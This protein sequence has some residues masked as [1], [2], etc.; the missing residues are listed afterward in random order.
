MRTVRNLAIASVS[1]LSLAT[2]AYAQDAEVD[3]EAVSGTEIIVSARRRDEQIQEVPMVVQAVTAQELANLNIREFKDIQSLVPGLSLGQSA[4]GIGAQASLRGIAFDVNASGNNG[5]IEF[6]MNDAHISAGMLFQSLFDV[7]QIEVQR[8]PQG[9][10]RGRASPSGSI[11][12]TTKKPDLNEVGGYMSGTVNDIGGWNVNGAMNVPIIADKLAI[13][14]AGIVDENDDNEVRSI[15]S[16]LEPSRKTQGIRASVQFNPFDILDL[17]FSYTSSQRK[18][19]TFDQ[20]VS[21][22]IADPTLPASPL[23]INGNQRLS[24]MNVPRD[25][26]QQFKVYN[27]QAELRLFGQKLNYVGAIN[28]QRLDSFAPNDIGAFFSTAFP[29]TAFGAGQTTL[30]LSTEKTH[31]IRLSNEERIAGIFDYVIGHLW[32]DTDVPTAL[33]Q[34]TVLFASNPP[35]ASLSNLFA[36]IN[37]P[38]NRNG[39]TSERS[40]YGNITAHIGE[41]TEISGGVRRIKYHSDG[42]LLINNV[43]VPAANEDR[44][45]HATIFQGAVK[46]RLN[47]NLLAY[48][49]Y[50]TSWRPGSATNSIIFRDNIAPTP[51]LAALY[52]PEAEKSKSVEV[53][54]KTDFLDKR[55]RFNLSA[56]HQTFD[57]FAFSARSLIFGGVNSANVNSV[58]VANPAIAV[59]VPAKVDGIEGELQFRASDRWSLGIVAAY[60]K[61]KLRNA[62]IP[63][64][65][66]SP[67]DGQ[68]DTVSTLPD[69]ATVNT[70]SGGDNVQFCTSNARAGSGAPF[71]ATVQS[72]YNLPVFANADGYIRGL[73]T[74]NGKSQNDP[75]N[76]FDDVKAYAVVNLFAGIRGSD[77]DWELGLFAKN[78]FNAQRAL[79]TG[80]TAS[81]T[82]YR[83]FA[84][85]FNGA[86]TYRTVTYTDPREFGVTLR[87]AF[88]SR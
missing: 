60:A 3:E 79:L 64:N 21:A 37:T 32:D 63:C 8:G 42:Q 54:I 44:T 74:Y 80:A 30:T 82:P 46:H 78:V 33:V 18:V 73:M 9:T 40:Y 58:F 6:Y 31:E 56:Y 75:I 84:G 16:S 45:L 59:G 51:A 52:F 25:F 34:Q 22:N 48:A 67:V 66:Y 11:T 24:V 19:I 23:A 77:G 53:G 61:S 27:W 4:N 50:G 2:P 57:N 7:G 83:T 72:E 26:Q 28:K 55:L 35:S 47:E 43:V 87:M 38:V 81:T 10:L 86:T 68:P 29:A 15:N 85:A 17:G 13:R 70:A 76:S 36:V 49:S 71:S 12:V 69:Y 39:T 1:L 62:T 41:A 20:V 14:V 88:G 65:D 5:T